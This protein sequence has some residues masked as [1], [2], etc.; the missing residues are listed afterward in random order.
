M[1][2]IIPSLNTAVS[3]IP[4]D[5]CKYPLFRAAI[6]WLLDEGKKFMRQIGN[7]EVPQ[8]AFLAVLKLDS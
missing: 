6:K 2:F 1:E 8:K 4:Q 5:N 7:V 3:L